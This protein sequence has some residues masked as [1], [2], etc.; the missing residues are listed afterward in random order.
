MLPIQERNNLRQ[1]EALNQRGGRM[2]SVVDLVAA[3][4]IS[5][6]MAATAMQTLAHGASILT[7]ARPGG[8]GKTTVL[9]AF[10]NLL[11]PDVT[12]VTVDEPGVVRRALERPAQQATCYL[13][14]EIGA[15]HWY[16]YLWGRPV[17]DYFRL[18]AGP[19][20]IASCLHADTLEELT[21]ILTGEPLGVELADLRRVGLL[22]F[23]HVSQQKGRLARRLATLYARSPFLPESRR[24]VWDAS[25]DRFV[26]EPCP[27]AEAPPSSA[28]EG[29]ADGHRTKNAGSQPRNLFRQFVD[30]LIE[31]DARSLEHVREEVLSF[32]A[33]HPDL[34]P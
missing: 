27:D 23:M 17:A 18:I 6:E 31:I 32:Y 14:H 24:F 5:R 20:R 2:L 3:G 21:T 4:T 12:I 33:A 19:R 11:P 22:G 13:V 7:A 30:H 28:R 25:Q 26:E 8:A 10:L 34:L 29:T 15:G 1:L 16:G 9:A